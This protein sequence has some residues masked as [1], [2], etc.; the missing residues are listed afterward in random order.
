M[1]VWERLKYC[2][3]EILCPSLMESDAGKV[4]QEL[5][6]SSLSADHPIKYLILTK[7]NGAFTM[8]R[9]LLQQ[10]AAHQDN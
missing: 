9:L 10:S 5:L 8:R 7:W 4:L 1:L 6:R 2:G 3:M